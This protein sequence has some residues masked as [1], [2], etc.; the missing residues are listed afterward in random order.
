MIRGLEH[1]FSFNVLG[2]GRPEEEMNKSAHRND[3]NR[4]AIMSKH[5]QSSNEYR[6]NFHMQIVQMNLG[7]RIGWT[8]SNQT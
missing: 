6:V 3:I 1:F 8:N 4:G 2:L 5:A 7:N